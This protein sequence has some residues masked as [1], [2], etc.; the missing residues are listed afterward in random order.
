MR[1]ERGE[2][3]ECGREQSRVE[4]ERRGEEQ[5]ELFVDQGFRVPW[6]HRQ[7]LHSNS[8]VWERQ[9]E[10]LCETGGREVQKEKGQ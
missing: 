7:G 9:L 6:Q 3:V 1:F 4:V 5:E 2:G 10:G 8:L